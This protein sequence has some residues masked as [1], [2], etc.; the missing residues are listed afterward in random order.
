M[1]W[2]LL[3]GMN[4][5]L[6]LIIGGRRGVGVLNHKFY[7]RVLDRTCRGTLDIPK[8]KIRKFNER[9]ASN[10]DGVGGKKLKNQLAGGG[11]LSET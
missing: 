4:F 8:N 5:F 1:G 11:R 6:K 7:R 2:E 10:K 3:G 9:R